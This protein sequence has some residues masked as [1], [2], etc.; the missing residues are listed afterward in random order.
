MPERVAETLVTLANLGAALRWLRTRRGLTVS[1]LAEKLVLDPAQVSRYETGAALPRLAVLDRIL[2]VLD[3]DLLRLGVALSLSQ[4]IQSVPLALPEGL[5]ER[6]RGAMLLAASAF[7]ELIEAVAD[8][9]ACARGSEDLPP[10]P[11]A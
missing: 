11:T 2:Q 9:S 6:E 8:R 7:R 10:R 3:T 5:S 4:G 1:E